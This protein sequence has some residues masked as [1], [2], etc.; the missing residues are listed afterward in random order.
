MYKIN[1]T[2]GSNSVLYGEGNTTGLSSVRQ[3][4]MSSL[5]RRRLAL[6]KSYESCPLVYR[7]VS[8]SDGSR[9]ELMNADEKVQKWITRALEDPL[10]KILMEKAHLTKIQLETLL[11]DML[12]EEIEETKI[13]YDEKAKMRV[14]KAKVSRGAFNR[15]LNQARKNV[16]GSLYIVFLLGYLGILDTPSLS[17][18]VEIS[19]RLERYVEAYRDLWNGVKSGS[20]DEEKL[21]TV[22]AIRE[23]IEVAFEALGQARTFKKR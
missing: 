2:V 14:S 16:I 13:G 21:K 5:Y 1:R 4:D 22:S 9:L 19:N 23:E 8:K 7:V 11:I 15:T 20:T 17:P 6:I 3:R 12:A 10:V 18:F